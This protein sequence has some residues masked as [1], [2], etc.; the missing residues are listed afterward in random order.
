MFSIHF[1]IDGPETEQLISNK[2]YTYN[3]WLS[4]LTCIVGD[5]F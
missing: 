3:I 4:K 2:N 5:A 1:E